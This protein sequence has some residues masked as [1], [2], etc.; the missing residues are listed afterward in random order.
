MFRSISAL[1]S[2]TVS[3][4]AKRKTIWDHMHC[5]GSTHKNYENLESLGKNLKKT[6]QNLWKFQ[7]SHNF[8]K[9]NKSQNFRKFKK[10]SKLANI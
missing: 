1:I 2:E 6:S 9:F 7:E 10:K 8:I 4:R 5:Q 3:D